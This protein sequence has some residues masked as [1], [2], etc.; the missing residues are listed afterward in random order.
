MKNRS[1][2]GI[3]LLLGTVVGT[4]PALAQVGLT[5]M[6]RPE[7]GEI[8]YGAVGAVLRRLHA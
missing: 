8:A 6:K 7:G 1:V 4:A 2:R 3:A 5:H